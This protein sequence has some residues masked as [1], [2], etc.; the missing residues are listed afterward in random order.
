[1]KKL[2]KTLLAISA[3]SAVSMAMAASAMAAPTATYDA[4]NATVKLSGVADRGVSQT[5]IVVPENTETVTG[6]NIYQI[7]Q[8]DGTEDAHGSFEGAVLKF[9]AEKLVDGTYEVRIGGSDGQMETATFTVGE[10]EPGE[11]TITVGDVDDSDK[12]NSLDVA[13]VARYVGEATEN[14]GNVGQTMNLSGEEGTVIIGDVDTSGAVNSLDV[15]FVARYVGEATEN[16]GQVGQT[17]TVVSE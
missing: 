5:L 6:D 8:I 2:S 12:I 15:T 3:V 1:M 13:Y 9:D 4:E 7:D 14:V 17:V 11:T 10:V 16:V